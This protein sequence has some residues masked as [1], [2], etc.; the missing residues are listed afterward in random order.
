MSCLIWTSV[1]LANL[2]RTVRPKFEV[3]SII[4]S[5]RQHSQPQT[6][7]V[8]RYAP[9]SLLR[10]SRCRITWL[11]FVT[12]SSHHEYVS[13]PG[14][15]TR[16]ILTKQIAKGTSSFGKRHNKS[17]TLCRRC[18]QFFIISL[19]DGT[20]GYR[21]RSRVQLLI[22]HFTGRRSLHIQKHTCSSC[23]YPAAKTRKCMSQCFQ[24][25]SRPIGHSTTNLM[26]DMD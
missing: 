2:N 9:Q 4:R 5:Q 23:G 11:T 25:S 1:F 15:P 7:Q 18:G 20:L 3:K 17:H 24:L 26:D 8:V 12:F 19:L 13:S 22:H 21:L 6:C 10:P 14:Y 16:P